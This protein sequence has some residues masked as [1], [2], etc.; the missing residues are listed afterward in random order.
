MEII[1]LEVG[2]LQENCYILKKNH[3][4]LIVDPGSE[5]KKIE[6]KIM[7]LELLGILVTHHHFD[8]VGALSELKTKYQ[9]PIYDNFTC[10]EQKYQIKPFTFDVIF[11][12]G[13]SEDSIS[14]Y[15]QEQNIMF[16]GDF[17]FQGTVGRCDLAGGNFAKM[18]A[19]IEKI[20]K[21]DGS[22]ILYPGHGLPT[23]LKE[24]MNTN[25]Y[26]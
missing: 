14:F 8:H 2:Y 20:K 25:P 13:H 26:F 11:N 16:V 6:E 23:T 17:I 15:F 18:Q 21:Y 3:Q 5:F 10:Q 24:E 12:P 4:C 1:K 22:I 7:G 19:S 9:V